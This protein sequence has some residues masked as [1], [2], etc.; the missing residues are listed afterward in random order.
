MPQD[1]NSLFYVKLSL[2]PNKHNNFLDHIQN[3]ILTTNNKS[4]VIYVNPAFSRLCGYSAKELIGNNPGILHSGRHDK[5]FYEDM[6]KSIKEKGSWEGE[7]WNRRKT[8][9]IYPIYLTISALSEVDEYKDHYVAVSTDIS[10]LKKDI[11]QKLQLALYDPLT[12]LPNRTLYHD[13]VT[14]A[15]DKGKIDPTLKHAIFFMDLDKFKQVNDTYGHLA[16]DHLLKLVGQRL[17]SIIRAGDTVA[18][19][20]GDEFTVILNDIKD[21]A[22]VE[23]LAKRIVESIEQ[24][25]EVDGHSVNVSISI[26]ISFYPDDSD[27]M[28]DLLSCAD[29]AMYVAKRDKSKIEFFDTIK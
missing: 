9:E 19:V 4:E 10:Y 14:H 17:S 22:S 8:G 25:F 13:R 16:G 21:K 5:K 26:G 18:R 23:L 20:G 3:G 28:D 2:N 6:W 1:N 15:I 29:K 7:I 11:Y 24:P 12:E 27:K